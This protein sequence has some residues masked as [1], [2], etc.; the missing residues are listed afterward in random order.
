MY[1]HEHKDFRCGFGQKS[2]VQSKPRFVLFKP[3]F[4]LCKP[5]FV[6]YNPRFVLLSPAR[7]QGGHK[8]STRKAQGIHKHV[9]LPPSKFVFRKQMLKISFGGPPIFQYAVTSSRVFA[10]L[11]LAGRVCGSTRETLPLEKD[12]KIQFSHTQSAKQALGAGR[13]EITVTASPD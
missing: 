13:L 1:P 7:A 11:G 9:P 10:C 5:R 6:V 12:I 2:V 4:V 8:E 3:R